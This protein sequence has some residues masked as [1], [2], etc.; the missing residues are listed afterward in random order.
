MTYC[1]KCRIE[2][3][4]N[5]DICPDCGADIVNEIPPEIIEE[6]DDSDWV[7]LHIFPGSLYA[8][9]AVEMLLREGISAYS[10]TTTSGSS[11]YMYGGGAYMGASSTVYVV[12]SDLDSALDIIQPMID[13]LPGEGEDYYFEYEN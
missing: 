8:R 12:E 1:P 9:M 3:Q 4:S 5:I 2:T 6:I 10:M 13:E 11:S 7:E